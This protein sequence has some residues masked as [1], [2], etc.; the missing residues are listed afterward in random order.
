MVTNNY[1][2]YQGGVVVAINTA[3]DALRAHGYRVIIVTFDFDGESHFEDDVIRIPALWRFKYK[4]KPFAVPRH[5]YRSLR[6]IIKQYKP[7]II[8]SHHP[9]LLGTVAY[10]EARRAGIPIVFTYHTFY[11][12]YPVPR[13]MPIQLWQRMIARMVDRYCR[14]VDHIIVPSRALEERVKLLSSSFSYVPTGI[15]MRWFQQSNASREMPIELL[16]VSRLSSEKNIRSLIDAVAHLD[17][18][19]RLTIIGYGP[20]YEQLCEYAYQELGLSPQR[21]QFIINPAKEVIAEWYARAFLFLFASRHEGQGLVLAEAMA[22]GTPVIAFPGS[23]VN[24]IVCDSV[25]G[26]LVTD[27]NEMAIAIANMAYD[28]GRYEKLVEGAVST[29]QR[30]H[31]TLF[32]N[33]L[34]Q[35][36]TSCIT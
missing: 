23:G 17:D 5:P 28:N 21:V 11:E 34:A 13:I 4:E 27:S 2:P 22:S 36:Y 6:R 9:F 26:F 30:Y 3:R 18:T 19:F 15:D 16:T 14:R 25:N 10:H 31:P 20:E 33:A 1:T 12:H 8:H 32:G 29:A 7:C 35:V 24:D